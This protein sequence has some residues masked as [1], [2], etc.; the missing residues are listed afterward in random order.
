[1]GQ[2]RPQSGDQLIPA[3]PSHCLGG[4]DVSGHGGGEKGTE[5]VDNAVGGGGEVI[6]VQEGVPKN[7]DQLGHLRTGHIGMGKSY[8]EVMGKSY[9]EVMGKSYEEVMGKS[10]EEVMGKSYE[11]VMGKSYEV[12]GK[13]YE[14][15][16]GKSYEEVM[17]KSYEVM[18]KSYEEVMGK[19]YE[20]VMGTS[21]AKVM[22]KS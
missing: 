21:Y 11:E 10:Y 17:G 6:E 13:S 3:A 16:M 9:E 1:M 22:G 8:E 20:E 14:E 5:E 18:G 2:K 15:V 4:G 7:V 12:M 19:S